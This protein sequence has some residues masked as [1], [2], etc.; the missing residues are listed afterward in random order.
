MVIPHKGEIRT[1]TFS[2]KHRPIVEMLNWVI[3]PKNNK[4][5]VNYEYV[6]AKLYIDGIQKTIYLH[7]LIKGRP[8]NKNH[9][10]DHIDRN[11]L[12]NTEE[13]LRVA[14]RSINVKNSD[15]ISTYARIPS[16]CSI[17]DKKHYARGFCNKHYGKWYREKINS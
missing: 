17:C 8:L 9:V 7:H 4:W 3:W 10:I 5:G 14:S 2:G 11:P 6:A 13:N 12:N 1:V 16:K 15:K